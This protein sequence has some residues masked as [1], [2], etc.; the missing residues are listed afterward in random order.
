MLTAKQNLTSNAVC[1]NLHRKVFVL[2][3]ESGENLNK[4]NIAIIFRIQKIQNTVYFSHKNHCEIFFNIFSNAWHFPGKIQKH[5]FEL[6]KHKQEY[7]RHGN[8]KHTL[9]IYYSNNKHINKVNLLSLSYHI[10]NS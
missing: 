10:S 5:M 6:M 2:K 3:T 8:T 7:A 4:F 9:H 1:A